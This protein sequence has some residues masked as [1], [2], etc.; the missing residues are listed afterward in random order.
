VTVRL[1]KPCEAFRRERYGIRTRDGDRVEAETAR[2]AIDQ[3][4]KI[5]WR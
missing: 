4:A 1:D 2:L 5:V 3:R